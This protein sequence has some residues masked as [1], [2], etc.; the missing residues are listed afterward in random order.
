MDKKKLIGTIIGVIAFAAIIAG[1]TYAW[2]SVTATVT[3]DGIR[4]G[5]AKNFTFQ[6][7][8]SNAIGNLKQIA[9]GN[10]TTGNIT[11]ETSAA[12]ANDGWIALTAS[13]GANSAAAGTFRIKAH[14]TTNNM[15][16]NSIIYVVCKGTC[17]DS[18]LATV[19]HTTATPPVATASCTTTASTT[20]NNNII[21]ACGTLGNG[22]GAANSNITL[23]DDTATFNTNSAASATYNVY[24]WLDSGTLHNSDMGK[25]LTGYIYA[26]AAQNA[27]GLS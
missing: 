3:N 23:Y 1:A 4:N 11:S 9:S 19:T 6:Y 21:V 12:T 14:I 27:A 16:T 18:A 7:A 5:Y 10:A 26:E 17:P 22:Q 8:G 25:T 24:L 2:L 13:K 15:Y 20:S